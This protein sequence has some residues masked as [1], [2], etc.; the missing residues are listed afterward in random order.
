MTS[1]HKPL[2]REISCQI[3]RCGRSQIVWLS[4]YLEASENPQEIQIDKHQ[5]N[6]LHIANISYRGVA[7]TG[8]IESVG[9]AGKL[10]EFEEF[11]IENAEAE[12]WEELE[13]SGEW[14]CNSETTS[15]ADLGTTGDLV[16]T[17]YNFLD[18]GETTAAFVFKTAHTE[19]Q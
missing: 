13:A 7:H 5:F 6:G 4:L 9:F 12:D 15:A 14:E 17:D 19:L 18:M 1:H 11:V 16:Q 8:H 3:E 2:P 10:S